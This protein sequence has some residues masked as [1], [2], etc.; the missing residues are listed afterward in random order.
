MIVQ[1]KIY[2]QDDI[3]PGQISNLKASDLGP[4]AQYWVDMLPKLPAG[5]THY[6][7][8][9]Q[10]GIVPSNNPTD[11]LIQ[12]VFNLYYNPGLSEMG[13]EIVRL[14]DFELREGLVGDQAD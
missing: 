3:S 11:S 14:A 8:N 12:E 4:T 6:T 9:F 13:D 10:T 1:S 5:A 7:D 2:Y